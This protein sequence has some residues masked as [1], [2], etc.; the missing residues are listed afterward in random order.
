[1]KLVKWDPIQEFE[2]MQHDINKILTTNSVLSFRGMSEIAPIDM[3]KSD[4]KLTI[5]MDLP[6]FTEDEITIEQDGRVLHVQAEHS[7]RAVAEKDYVIRESSE[8]LHR[9]FIIPEEADPDAIKTTFKHGVLRFELPLLK[10]S[11]TKR[12]R[13]TKN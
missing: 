4:G 7:E 13:I 8:S 3:Y 2:R 12:L 1:M 10:L 6:R 11:A 5:D 9:S